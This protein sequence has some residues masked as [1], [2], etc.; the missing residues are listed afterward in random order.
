MNSLPPPDSAAFERLKQFVVET[1]GLAYYAERDSELMARV[2]RRIGL[3]RVP[4]LT[5]YV[6]LLTDAGQGRSEFD[7]LISELTIGE[8]YFF[9]DN[10]QLHA[11]MRIAIPELLARNAVSRRLSIWS[12]GCATGAEPYSLAMLLDSNF[13]VELSG[14]QVHIL[15]TDINR[16]YIVQAREGRFGKWA[17]RTTPDDVRGTCFRREGTSWDILPKYKSA[18]RF[19]YHN[20]VTD[21][22]PPVGAGT[23]PVDLI[24]CRNVFIYFNRTKIRE[25][26]ERFRA[27]L[28]DGGWLIVGHAEFELG[29]FRGFRTTGTENA[30][31]H[32]KTGSAA[33]SPPAP[34]PIAAVPALATECAVPLANTPLPALS[35]PAVEPEAGAPAA[36]PTIAEV[37][38]LADAGEWDGAAS[39]VERLLAREPLDA[40]AHLYHGLILEH[41]GELESAAR[42]LRR[43]IYLQRDFIMA[44]YHLGLLQRARDPRRAARSFE[45]ALKLAVRLAADC[46]IDHADGATAAEVC[47]MTKFQIEVLKQ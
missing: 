35:L 28:N 32:Q 39:V 47:E 21:S 2:R 20:L 8:T 36:R 17:F 26:V 44:H 1:T 41:L 42:A 46:I 11:L 16:D 7:A 30:I 22:F 14:W 23:T 24:L 27:V 3:A 40:R 33:P 31:L 18:V 43:A 25:I 12:A 29:G 6:E 4:D 45:T 15:A 34:V 10:S 19:E 5:T 37:T 9:R 38:L 13:G